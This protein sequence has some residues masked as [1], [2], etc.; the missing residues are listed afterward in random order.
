VKKHRDR[1]SLVVD[2]GP[3]REKP[4]FGLTAGTLTVPIGFMPVDIPVVYF[5]FTWGAVGKPHLAVVPKWYSSLENL[6]L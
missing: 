6:E 5:N 4:G 2:N 1:L 3:V